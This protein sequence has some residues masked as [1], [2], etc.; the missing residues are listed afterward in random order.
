MNCNLCP[1]KCNIDRSN[2]VGY[3][4]QNETLSLAQAGLHLWEEPLICTGNGSGAI[5]FAGCNLRCVYCQNFDV[6]RGRGKEITTRRLC[7]I[8]KELEDKGACNINLVTPTHYSRQIVDA[9][10]I[11]KPNLPIMY[12]CGGYES[13]ATLAMLDGA[14]DIYLPD[15]KYS[16]NNLAKRLSNVDDYFE[17]ACNAIAIMR[18]QV[19]KDIIVNK[20][21]VAQNSQ[22][23][24]QNNPTIQKQPSLQNNTTLQNNQPSLQKGMIIR[25]LVLPNHIDNTLNVIDYLDKNIAHDTIISL[26]GQ[27]IPCGRA[28]EFVDINRRLKPLE[29]KIAIN[30]LLNCGFEN[31]YVQELS[32][33][34]K[35][36]IP[37]FDFEGV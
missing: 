8:F 5:F 10:Q 36:Y 9:L 20:T 18:Q 32:S 12:N 16:D 17:I 19:G 11:Y 2:A 31:S 21:F 34:D 25:H 4:S 23:S 37:P 29:Y 26:L 13:A 28:N 24:L 15:L 6:S 22:S 14:I 33:S 1:R 27:Y 30:H 3:C 35:A 7:D